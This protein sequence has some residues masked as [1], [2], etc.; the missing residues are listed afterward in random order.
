MFPSSVPAYNVANPYMTPVNANTPGASP[1]AQGYEMFQMMLDNILNAEK[2][3]QS[4]VNQQVDIANLFAQLEKASPS[5][6]ANLAVRLGV[7]GLEP[8][9]SYANAF[10]GPGSTGTFGGKVG[11]QNITLPFAF[12][13]SELAF[14][15]NNPNLSSGISDIA[16]ALG[17]P[18]VLRN[19]MA[20]LI[21]T[22]SNLFSF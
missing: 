21:P 8:D 6:A 14:L 2:L 11:S 4:A 12:S 20:S 16:A 17:R 15:G 1:V 10:A 18:D 9:L 5:Q 3:R 7:P 22:N 13:G 19:S